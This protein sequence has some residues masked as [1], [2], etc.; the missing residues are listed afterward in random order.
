MKEIAN[1]LVAKYSPICKIDEH[2]GS[3]EGDITLVFSKGT[4]EFLNV[5]LKTDSIDCDIEKGIGHPF[6]TLYERIGILSF[7]NLEQI[8]FTFIENNKE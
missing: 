3:E 2:P 8:I 5:Y 6:K 1:F 7:E 4:D